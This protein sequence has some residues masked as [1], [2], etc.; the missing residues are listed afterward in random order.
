MN[1]QVFIVFLVAFLAF[2]LLVPLQPSIVPF[3]YASSNGSHWGVNY[4]SDNWQYNT[5]DAILKRDFLL[6]NNSGIDI[7]SVMLTWSA[8]EPFPGVFNTAF[9]NRIIHLC[10]IANAY[11]IDVMMDFHTLSYDNSYTIPSWV[12]PQR[13]ATVV[14]NPEIRNSWLNYQLY[15][16]NYFSGIK[17]LHS[18]QIMNEP[19]IT[20]HGET[21]QGFVDLWTDEVALFRAHSDLPISL[22]FGCWSFNAYWK[23]YSKIYDLFDYMSYNWYPAKGETCLRSAVDL[24]N[25]HGLQPL[26]TEYG[27]A[28]WN[29]TDQDASY[30]YQINLF[31][32]MGINFG[33]AWQ[34]GDFDGGAGY[35]LYNMTGN[36]VRPA[37][38]RIAQANDV[39]GVYV[40][41]I[42]LAKTIIEQGYCT[43]V[44]VTVLNECAS[45]ESF[46]LDV[47]ANSTLVDMRNETV[48]SGVSTVLHFTCNMTVPCGKYTINVVIEPLPGQANVAY[49]HYTGSNIT[50]TVKGDLNGDFTANLVD[51]T[52]LAR[53][54]GSKPGN[55][56][57]NP[58]ADINN[59]GEVD[60]PDLATLARAL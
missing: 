46:L 19:L 42:T 33:L 56:N 27:L 52:M 2:T 35:S 21:Q 22:R 11:G 20:G 55:A 43:D 8:I 16:I 59:N 26:I 29:D 24:A 58:N 37:F 48:Q 25:S 14:L 44:E 49:N 60:L 54:F 13:L 50:V 45:P 38:Y 57:W 9:L 12:F 31:K 40:L 41:E 3:V 4:S 18:W 32:S 36:C 15:V 7:I 5:D 1:A 10:A 28:D 17:N 34:Y 39:Q 30:V 51:L 47:Y 6:F 23:N 53:A